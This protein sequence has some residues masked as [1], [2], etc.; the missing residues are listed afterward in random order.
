MRY[1]KW[2]WRRYS[3]RELVYFSNF[4]RGVQRERLLLIAKYRNP[5]KVAIKTGCTTA[6]STQSIHAGIRDAL[7][8]L[9]QIRER[10]GAALERQALIMSRMRV[11]KVYPL[12]VE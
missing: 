7:W 3:S 9:Q 1:T 5:T 10:H 12:R 6:T 4:T 2:Q 8:R 11:V